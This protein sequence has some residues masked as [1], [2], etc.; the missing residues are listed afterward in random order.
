MTVDEIIETIETWYAANGYGP[1]A[2]MLAHDVLDMLRELQGP[3]AAQ[4]LAAAGERFA[5]AA[6][7]GGVVVQSR[8]FDV[9]P[10]RFA[11]IAENP[12]GATVVRFTDDPKEVEP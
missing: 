1:E 4:Q 9:V 2:A 3:N 7:A 12:D 6:E 8:R 10:G 11:L 5:K